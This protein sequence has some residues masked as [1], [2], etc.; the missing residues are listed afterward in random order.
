MRSSDE[1]SQLPVVL[2]EGRERRC[3][4]ARAM[5]VMFS[6]FIAV[7]TV[8]A[9]GAAPEAFEF[10]AATTVAERVSCQERVRGGVL[11]RV[12]VSNEARVGNLILEAGPFEELGFRLWSVVWGNEAESIELQRSEARER[13]RIRVTDRA[14]ADLVADWCDYAGMIEVDGPPRTWKWYR[15]PNVG[16][17]TLWATGDGAADLQSDE[18]MPVFFVRNNIAA[19]GFV[20]GRDLLTVMRAVDLLANS[21]RLVT[22]KVKERIHVRDEVRRRLG[23]MSAKEARRRGVEC[24]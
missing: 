17:I 16:D 18:I 5:S 21:G 4:L 1:R 2:D 20:A 22:D 12:T 23:G 6:T 8:S 11:S 15:L 3:S 9:F 13:I 10:R 19:E 14:G 7:A 24:V